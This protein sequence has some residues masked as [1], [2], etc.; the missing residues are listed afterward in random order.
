MLKAALDIVRIIAGDSPTLPVGRLII[1]FHNVT[2]CCKEQN[3]DYD[4]YIYV[5]RS[6]AEIYLENYNET[7]FIS[8]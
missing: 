5:F 8:K 3:E 1:S 4:A 2:N 6:L 7:P